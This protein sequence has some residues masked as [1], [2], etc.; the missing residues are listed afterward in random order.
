VVDA[1]EHAVLDTGTFSEV[2]RGRD[3]AVRAKADAY[4]S[5]FGRFTLSVTTVTELVDGFRRQDDNQRIDWLLT[6]IEHEQHEILSIDWEAAK[7][8]GHVFGDLHRTGQPIGRSDP[9]I[10]AV[11]IRNSLPLVTGNT[12]HFERIQAPGYP[13]RLENWRGA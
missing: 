3:V 9:F 6:M 5:V 13:L 2:L 1:M 11:A 10:A 12:K 8:A 7:I 4:L